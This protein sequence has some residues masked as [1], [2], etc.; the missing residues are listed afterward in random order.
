MQAL[1][2]LKY[3]YVVNGFTL[4]CNTFYWIPFNRKYKYI[5]LS[6]CFKLRQPKGSGAFPIPIC[7]SSVCPSVCL[8]V[9]QDW[10]GEGSIFYTLIIMKCLYLFIQHLKK[11]LCRAFL[12]VYPILHMVWE[13][14]ML[15]CQLA[16][17]FE[18]SR[19]H[20]PFLRW[21][22]VILQ[23]L[24]EEDLQGEVNAEPFNLQNKT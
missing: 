1:W 3:K 15:G 4:I 20:S 11:R 19:V 14:T 16:Y 7:L 13:S 17:V 24:T 23:N 22:G 18:K 9:R 5:K 12:A 10:G 21:A 8:S 6:W 2:C